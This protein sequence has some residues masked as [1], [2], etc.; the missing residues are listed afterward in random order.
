MSKTMVFALAHVFFAQRMIM[1]AKNQKT[2]NQCIMFEGFVSS[3]VVHNMAITA[4]KTQSVLVT[5]QDK[6]VC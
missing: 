2:W 4:P 5:I 6:I 3:Q 1:M